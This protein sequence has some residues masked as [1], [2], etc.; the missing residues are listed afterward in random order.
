MAD[1]SRPASG[2]APDPATPLAALVAAL[3]RRAFAA[4]LVGEGLRLLG[5]A[6][7]LAGSWALVWRIGFGAEGA[8]TW[9]GFGAVLVAAP[10]AFWRARRAVPS[11]A[12]A[13]TW[14]DARSGGAGALVT[15]FELG[16]DA[17]WSEAVAL[18]ARR[19][20]PPPTVRPAAL[21][22]P[23]P[24]TLAFALACVLVPVAEPAMSNTRGAEELL[25]R[26]VERARE[27]LATL[28]E[29]VA[30]GDET[31][32]EL[33]ER[34]ERL[35]R[36]LEGAGVEAGFEGLD[37]L[38]QELERLAGQALDEALS[39]E[40]A[41]A[42]SA[43]SSSS[44]SASTS[45]AV[46]QAAEQLA[47]GALAPAADEDLL[48]ALQELADAASSRLAEQ[49]GPTD[50]AELEQWLEWME[51]WSRTSEATR[52]SLRESLDRLVEAG[53]VDED[54]RAA[55]E[56][57]AQAL[58]EQALDELAER[59]AQ[60]L[61][62]VE[63][64]PDEAARLRE[65]LAGLPAAPQM[66]PELQEA[67]ARAQAEIAERLG[68]VELP[69][70]PDLS[71][72]LSQIDGELRQEL[73]EALA[74]AQARRN[75]AFE[76]ALALDPQAFALDEEQVAALLRALEELENG[77]AQW[78]E[79]EL[80]PQPDE[81]RRALASA[82]SQALDDPRTSEALRAALESALEDLLDVD[83]ASLARALASL[84]PA[85]R[86]PAL[87]ELAEQFAHAAGADGAVPPGLSPEQSAA[88]ADTLERL[89]DGPPSPRAEP[90]GAA[91]VQRAIEALRAMQPGKPG[92][93]IP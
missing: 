42:R 28:E 9:A 84:P 64:D 67:L 6:F 89:A 23:W 22:G 86:E 87:R 3:R 14:L 79:A 63:L 20:P 32:A 53:L 92:M 48:A 52:A 5:V 82:L 37:A 18:Q 40:Q 35:E 34:L 78:M 36:D 33:R 38:E 49:G 13:A 43:A 62:D 16:E 26:G 59:L 21:L 65:E 8:T 70:G 74:D 60:A 93:G 45:R 2:L 57:S 17:R 80:Q 31:R 30:L 51:A 12:A 19:A 56:L 29:E 15:S 50:M 25:E 24:L 27:R 54:E 39:V 1:R 88:L 90:L 71:E 61:E 4:A 44:S 77:L 81:A 55:I 76:K 46:E 69:A 7:V 11:P 85:L 72:L 91:D 58:D 10:I 73:F 83:P 68:D 66:S 47:S 41:L 75:A